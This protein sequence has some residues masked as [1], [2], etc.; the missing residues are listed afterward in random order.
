M[1][2]Y[3]AAAAKAMGMP[4]SIV[5]RS[6]ESRAKAI[7]ASVD[8]VLRAWAAGEE[9][10]AGAGQASDQTEQATAPEQPVEP[11]T[12]APSEPAP[13]APPAPSVETSAEPVAPPQQPLNPR[14]VPP[15]VLDG[16][17]DR[18]FAVMLSSVVVLAVALLISLVSP[19]TANEDIGP[20]YFSAVSLSE[21]GELGRDVYL[22]EGCAACHTQLVR[23]IVADA[24]LGGVTLS[25]S[26]QVLGSRRYGPDLMHVGS[27]YSEAEIEQILSGSLNHAAY[28]LEEADLANLVAYLSESR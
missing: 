9:P 16:R 18:P 4:E 7:G 10:E 5:R 13:P 20:I 6:A 21:R 17:S 26:N 2:E 11:D 25:D 14:P 15:P 23:P 8:D 24:G 12:S 3:L 28:S 27:R 22:Q 19:L 1:S